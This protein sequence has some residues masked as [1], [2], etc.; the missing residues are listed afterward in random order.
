MITIDYSLKALI[1][2]FSFVSDPYLHVFIFVKYDCDVDNP[3][4]RKE[5]VAKPLM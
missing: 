1:N 3:V 5:Q 4:R 2:F